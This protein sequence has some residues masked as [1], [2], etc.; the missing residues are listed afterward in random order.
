M[1]SNESINFG[2]IGPDTSLITKPKSNLG[3][4][5]SIGPNFKT[6]PI[7]EEGDIKIRRT[8]TAT[9]STTGPADFDGNKS[10]WDAFSYGAKLGFTDTYRGA[11][12][13]FGKD[14][15]G[16]RD[17]QQELYA[18]MADDE[19][20]FW[21][22]A[23]YF[24]GAILD[25][26]TWIIPFAKAKTVYQMAKMGAISGGFFG[27]TGYVDE[28]SILDTR[29]KQ[30]FAGIVG[31]SIITPA[32]GQT[33]K[34]F[35][36]KKLPGGVLPEGDVSVRALNEEALKDIKLIGSMGQGPRTIKIRTDKELKNVIDNAT[37]LELRDI[38]KRK[39]ILSFTPNVTIC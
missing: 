20:G 11:K 31:G 14:L 34:I 24:G 7:T 39:E 33:S 13:M 29:T 19:Y 1:A 38:V 18:R 6:F 30:A 12:Q 32:I 37:P 21:T 36:K 26:I 4:F 8:D 16:M 35:R 5:D 2:N 23:G 25:P 10:W 9:L 28:D 3:N 22:T 15:E 17:Q 27:A